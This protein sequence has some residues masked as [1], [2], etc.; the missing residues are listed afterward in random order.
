M[1]RNDGVASLALVV[2]Y[3]D[4]VASGTVEGVP[5]SVHRTG[6]GDLQLRFT[7]SLLAGSALAPAEFARDTP[8]PTF[9]AVRRAD[10]QRRRLP[11]CHTP[12]RRNWAANRSGPG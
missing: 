4:G 9:G 11:G 5:D 1:T 2:P 10:L 6:F 12:S 8:D 7:T 3:A